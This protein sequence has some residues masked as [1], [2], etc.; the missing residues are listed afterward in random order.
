MENRQILTLA[1]LRAEAEDVY[2]QRLA[3]IAPA[4]DRVSGGFSRDDGATVRKVCYAELK[5]NDKTHEFRDTNIRLL[6]GL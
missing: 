5:R 1:R 6:P 2:G 4:A 3:D